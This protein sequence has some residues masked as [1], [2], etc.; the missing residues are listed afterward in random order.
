[1]KK[2]NSARKT[3]CLNRKKYRFTNQIQNCKAGISYHQYTYSKAFSH[4]CIKSYFA[5]TKYCGVTVP[6]NLHRTFP[7]LKN[8][9]IRIIRASSQKAHEKN[10]LNSTLKKLGHSHE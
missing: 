3:L 7:L 1:M 2:S 10:D 8:K 4:P 6:I 9:K 5:Y